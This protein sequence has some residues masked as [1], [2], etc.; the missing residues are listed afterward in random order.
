MWSDRG[1]GEA[2]REGK[3]RGKRRKRIRERT[4]ETVVN[5]DN[6][7]DNNNDENDEETDPSLATSSPSRFNG[8]LGLIETLFDVGVDL[9]GLSFNHLDT[10]VLFEN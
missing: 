9:S 7:S 10:F 2:E 6:N 4:Y 8:F 3:E 1:E 5:T